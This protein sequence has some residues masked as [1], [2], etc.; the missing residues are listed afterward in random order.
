M[1]EEK[2]SKDSIQ[3]EALAAIRG[4]NRS[5]VEVSMGVGKCMLGLKDMAS[6]YTETSRYL[7]IAPKKAIY[8]SWLDDMNNF[9]FEYL[10]DHVKFNTYRSLIKE[11]YDY[12]VVYLDECHSLKGTHNPWL[13][14]YIKKGGRV[15]G[16]TGTY[17]VYKNTEKGKMC[18]YYCPKVYVYKTDD[19]IEDSILNDYKIVVHE[20]MLSEKANIP[21][22]GQYG[23]YMTSEMKDYQYWCSRVEDANSDQ[24]KAIAGIQRMK[25]LQKASTK[26]SYAKLLT[27]AQT[28]KTIVFANTQ[29]QA[30]RICGAS[31]HSSNADSE[32]NLTAFKKGHITKIS[33]VEQLSEGV[34]VPDLK[35]GVIMHSY[36]N[37]RKAPQKIGRLLRLNPNDTATIHVLCYVN[38]VD[39]VWVKAALKGFNQD[40]IEWIKPLYHAGVHY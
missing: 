11:D 1:N 35:V 14:E 8:K 19:A 16:L 26:E 36:A 12:D 17:P 31:F 28:D 38:S 34:S 32:Y 24:Q 37:N 25:S 6:I 13:L 23:D 7:V 5:G 18:N 39:K 40:K 20:L 30:D 3:S 29:A 2:K 27:E 10:K 33:A 9:K 22:K 21:M 15:V 4:K